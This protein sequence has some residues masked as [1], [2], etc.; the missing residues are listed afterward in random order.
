MSSNDSASTNDSTIKGAWIQA[1]ATY[2]GAFLA[3]IVTIT[4]GVYA[5]RVTVNN[6][7]LAKDYSDLQEEFKSLKTERDE[8]KEKYDKLS[9]EKYW[10]EYDVSENEVIADQGSGCSFKI[11]IIFSSSI[12]LYIYNSNEP[13]DTVRKSLDLGEQILLDKDG[14][15]SLILLSVENDT[16]HVIV[17]KD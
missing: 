12:S 14:E 17:K 8:L 6:S 13:S 7:T 11:D 3:A 4:M 5:A 1:K 10:E 2:V 16:C 9:S 15:Y